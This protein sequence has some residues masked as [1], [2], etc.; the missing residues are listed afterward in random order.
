M[1]VTNDEDF[2]MTDESVD[3][4]WVTL[5]ELRG[6]VGENKAQQRAL[7]MATNALALYDALATLGKLPR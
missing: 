7:E 4:R 1:A 5:D 3:M 6:L 2:N